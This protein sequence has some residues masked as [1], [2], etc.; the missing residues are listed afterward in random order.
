MHVLVPAVTGLALIGA[1]SVAAPGA[2]TAT[3]TTT[4][5]TATTTT[6]ASTTA[7]PIGS[8][9]GAA[10]GSGITIN[11]NGPGTAYPSNVG[12]STLVGTVTDVDLTIQDFTHENPRDVDLMLVNTSTGKRALLM[13][14]VGGTTPVAAADITFDDEASQ[15]IPAASPVTSSAY[16]PTNSGSGDAFPAPAPDGTSAGSALSV[17]DGLSAEAAAVWNLYVVDDSFLYAGSIQE[18]TLELTTTGSGVYPATITVSGAGTSVTDVD[19]ALRGLSHTVPDDVDMLLVGPDGQQ[20]TILSDAISSDSAYAVD[21]VIDDSAPTYVP[22]PIGSGTYRPTNVRTPPDVFPAPAP[23]PTDESALAVFNGTDPN[24][25]WR[26]FVVDDDDRVGRGELAG[27]SLRITTA[28]AVDTTRPRVT[29]T[30]PAGG[31]TGVARNVAVRATLSEAVRPTS[32]S[33]ATAYLVQ[34]TTGRRVQ[35]AVQWRAATRSLVIDPVRDLA[36]RTKYQAVVTSGV[37][38]LA[39]NPLDQSPTT[40]L[41]PKTWTFTTR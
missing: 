6:H 1:V 3:A 37:L 39:G 38:D 41:Q 7:V 8:S 16:R 30:A 23:L 5:A 10:E 36:S 18:W 14:D 26:L 11:D 22:N 29:S 35:A 21:L 12:F 15:E 31:A 20:A 19:V 28:G 17:F 2:A 40:G 4:T 24:G 27:W 13:S 34:V 25:T 9:H 33:T 32:V